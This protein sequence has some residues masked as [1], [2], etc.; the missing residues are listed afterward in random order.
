MATKATLMVCCALLAG[1]CS[2]A[3][4][5][6][7]QIVGL[8]QS[9]LKQTPPKP[10]ATWCVTF[11]PDSQHLA[12]SRGPFFF[13]GR[14]GASE[15]EVCVWQTQDWKPVDLEVPASTDHPN[16]VTFSTD[17]KE[18][19]CSAAAYHRTGGGNPTNGSEVFAWSW[20]DGKLKDRYHN[21]E[22]GPGVGELHV[23]PSSKLIVVR[24]T[25]VPPLIFERET[26]NVISLE[27]HAGL[28]VALS[29]HPDGKSLISNIFRDARIHRYEVATGKETATYS[30]EK[31]DPSSLK[32]SAD[33]NQIAVGCK[34][35]SLR[36][37][38]EKLTKEL[39]ASTDA[40]RNERIRSVAFTPD[41]KTI[42]ASSGEEVWLCD[43]MDGSTKQTLKAEFE[44]MSVAISPDGKMLAAGLSDKKHEH[45][46]VMVRDLS[47]GQLLKTLE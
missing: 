45:G 33:G 35:G 17:G 34:D 18:L 3:G 46:C 9:G 10:W 21:K 32:H 26:G 38:D 30:P 15:G 14:A 37:I 31:C 23:A 28:S 13:H 24:G 39:W 4:R 7:E 29:L 12:A 25:G 42:A 6:T 36:L 43:A 22:H 47:T 20:P 44:V 27:G 41:G 11:S 5:S 2:P 40:K 16:G 1:G 19:F 8:D